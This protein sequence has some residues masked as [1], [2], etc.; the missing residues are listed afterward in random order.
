M[1]ILVHHL[2]VGRPIFTVWQLEEM[3]LDYTL[4]LYDRNEIGRAPPELKEA[5]PLGKSPVI[6]IDGF[7]L[8]ETGAITQ[9]LVE[10]R[11]G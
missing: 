4:K 2:R 1:T 5:H 11:A 3:G 9:Y 7:T 6:E 8:A 10:T